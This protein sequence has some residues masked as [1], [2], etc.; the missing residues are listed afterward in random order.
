MEDKAKNIDKQTKG[1]LLRRRKQF[2]WI[3]RG[4]I[5]L[6][7]MVVYY[8][9]FSFVYDTPVERE[10]KQ[11]TAL[12]EQQYGVLSAR[13]DSI[14]QVLDNV[15]AR[16]C[17]VS[18]VLFESDPY[19]LDE[20]DGLESWE[21]REMLLTKTN[22]ELSREFYNKIENI[23]HDIKYLDHSYNALQQKIN[24]SKVAMRNIPAIQPIINNDLTLLTASFGLRIHPFYRK[25]TQHNGVDYTVPEG[26]RVFATADGVVKDITTRN[27]GSGLTLV[28]EH[29]GGYETT[30][31]H[32]FKTTVRRGERVRRGDI[33]ALTGNSGLSFAP[34]LHYEIKFNGLR[35]DPIHYFFMDL[36][37]VE[38]HQIIR[39]AQSG[40]QSFD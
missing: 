35:V 24:D 19:D 2:A 22:R 5:F 31:S 40:M 16:D 36:T 18:R 37:P 10:M 39:I 7:V 25:L 21:L 8:I 9:L 20:G 38:Y 14:M 13:Y 30:Y 12:L 33:V 1:R 34:H 6:G 4:L 11:S 23:E 17:N 32:L 15:V 29:E 27:T 28:L 3:V 26:T